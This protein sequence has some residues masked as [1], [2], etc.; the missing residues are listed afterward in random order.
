MSVGFTSPCPDRPTSETKVLWTVVSHGG[1][2]SSEGPGGVCVGYD[3]LVGEVYVRRRVFR[4][5]GF[6]VSIGVVSNSHSP[7]K[8]LEVGR[9]DGTEFFV[10]FLVSEPPHYCVNPRL[11]PSTKTT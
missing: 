9:N 8:G 3:L 4:H 1:H 7:I 10:L 5:R 6:V 11:T 2:P